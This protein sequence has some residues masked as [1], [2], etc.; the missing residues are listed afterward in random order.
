MIHRDALEDIAPYMPSCRQQRGSRVLREF[1]LYYTNALPAFLAK[2]V[3][4]RADRSIEAKLIRAWRKGLMLPARDCLPCPN[5]WAQRSMSVK[6]ADGMCC[7]RC[8]TE[9]ANP[10]GLDAHHIIHRSRGGTNR[11]KN[12]ISLCR[13][14]HQLQHDHPLSQLGEEPS[15]PQGLGENARTS[16]QLPVAVEPIADGQELL[17]RPLRGADKEA[18]EVAALHWFQLHPGALSM[19]AK[20]DEHLFGLLAL[21]AHGMTIGQA[22]DQ[23]FSY[24][25]EVT[26]VTPT[27]RDPTPQIPET[28]APKQA[29]VLAQGQASTDAGSNRRLLVISLLLVASAIGVAVLSS[30]SEPAP[31]VSV[32]DSIASPVSGRTPRTHHVL[33]PIDTMPADDASPIREP[34]P[35]QQVSVAEPALIA[36]EAANRPQDSSSD[37]QPM[38][39]GH[40]NARH[41]VLTPKIRGEKLGVK[42]V[43]PREAERQL[44]PAASGASEPTQGQQCPSGGELRGNRCC[45]LLGRTPV[46]DPSHCYPAAG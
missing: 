6:I 24:A 8:G 7:K 35:E 29:V 30:P 20:M 41:V 45:I 43:A 38:K 11:R 14:C 18:F 42:T 3:A 4:D 40:H 15:V 39:V 16:A 23:S 21:P 10:S 9:P 13:A 37:L 34:I 19:A 28:V 26:A 22:I 36:K 5:D 25:K 27:P 32:D 2:V 31:S 46:I 17:D 1:D 44:E 12:L 33:P